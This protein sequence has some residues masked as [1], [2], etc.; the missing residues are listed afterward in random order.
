MK[1][2]VLEQVWVPLTLLYEAPRCLNNLDLLILL[3]CAQYPLCGQ[4][5]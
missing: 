5:Q 4:S 2:M 3:A 1:I